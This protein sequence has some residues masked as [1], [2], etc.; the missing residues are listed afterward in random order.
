[1]TAGL[2]STNFV[3]CVAEIILNN[4]KLD[5]MINAIDGRNVQPCDSWRRRTRHYR[6]QIKKSQNLI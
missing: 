2:H 4:Q 3:G 1:M 6:A 5:I